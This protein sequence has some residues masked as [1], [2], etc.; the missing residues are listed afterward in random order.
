MTEMPPIHILVADD[1]L[2][3]RFLVMKGLEESRLFFR[4]DC[5]KDGEELIRFLNESETLPDLILSDLKMPRVDGLE[6]LKII[7]ETSRLKN[8]PFIIFS[9]S[10]HADDIRIAYELGA[11]KYITKPTHYTGYMELGETLSSVLRSSQE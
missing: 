8:I 9:T 11:A 4:I 3:D 6:A 1:D 10:D 2:A 5:V 7:K